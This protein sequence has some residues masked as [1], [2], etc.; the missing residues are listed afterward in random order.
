MRQQLIDAIARDRRAKGTDFTI[1]AQR[2]PLSSNTLWQQTVVP[3]ASPNAN[4]RTV[5]PGTPG[6]NPGPKPLV[7]IGHTCFGTIRD[8]SNRR[9]VQR[10]VVRLYSSIMHEYQH[11]LQWQNPARARRMGA[12]RREIEAYFW[13][14]EHSRQTGLSGQRG[15]FQDIWNEAQHWWGELSALD[16]PRYMQRCQSVLAIARGILGP[17]TRSFCGS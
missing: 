16:K 7:L 12:A 14:I 11:A 5:P 3:G 1:M 6:I 8:R 4:G 10:Y 9:M 2:R 17:R 13:E 15:P